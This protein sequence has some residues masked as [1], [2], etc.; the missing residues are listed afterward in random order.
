VSDIVRISISLIPVLAFLGVLV[1]LD[2]FNLVGLRFVIFVILTGCLGALASLLLN[3]W[4]LASFPAHATFFYRYVAPVIEEVAKA[5][6]LIYLI[7][8]KRIG[9]MVDAAI[10]GF[11]IG[12]GF[13]LTE[14]IYYLHSLEDHD[15]FLWMIRGFG[16]AVMHGGTTAI[17]GV[18]SKSLSDR[19]GTEGVAVFLPG[20]L[21][22]IAVHSLFNHFILPPVAN[23]VVQLIALPALAAVIFARSEKALRDWLEVGLDS[24]VS[25]LED[26][27]TGSLSDTHTGKYLNSL[28]TR[29]PGGVVADMLCLLRIHLELAVRAKGLLLMREA[30]FSVP[31]DLET[32]ERL[33]E[34]RFLERSIGATGR[35]AMSP[36]LHTSGRDRW[37][38]Y[39]VGKK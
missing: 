36:V 1:L 17:F 39:L 31:I 26:I 29:F 3:R 23:T 35:L 27:A 15:L 21:T 14:N 30:G 13:A 9:F 32:R 37:Q 2:S 24:D 33:D 28:R 38:L 22:A 8:K 7:R 4:G 25:V 18:L 6:F 34:M 19:R 12:A 20:L 10:I 5:G 16:T 11:A